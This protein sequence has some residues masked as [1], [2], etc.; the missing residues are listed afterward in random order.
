MT[1]Y[2]APLEGVTDAVF[3]RIHHECFPGVSKYFIPFISPTQNLAFT[4]RDWAAI[5]PENNIGVPAVPQLLAKD[6]ALFLWAAQ[7]LCDMGYPELNLN[8]GCPS[9]TVAAK[10][11]GSGLLADVPALER[12]LDGIFEKPPIP[13]SIKT[14][15]GYA[16][17]EEWDRLLDVFARYPIHELII[18]P[19]TRAEFYRGTPHA[20]AFAK[21][22]GTLGM[23]L[24]YNG[25]LFSEAA[26]F[27]CT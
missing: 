7:A 13:V 5:A 16:H 25:D 3:R 23:P 11:K 4:S 22:Y 14:R 18:H 12:L 19:R 21:A 24:C 17:V 1:L 20:D 2:F 6:A 9:G 15:I 26:I 10:G 27:Y 8:L